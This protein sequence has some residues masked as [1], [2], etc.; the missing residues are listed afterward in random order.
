MTDAVLPENDEPDVAKTVDSATDESDGSY[1]EDSDIEELKKENKQSE[2]ENSA[3]KAPKLEEPKTIDNLAVLAKSLKYPNAK[4]L[5]SDKKT[6]LKPIRGLKDLAAS[7]PTKKTEN[8]EN[9]TDA[10]TSKLEQGKAKSTDALVEPQGKKLPVLNDH[11]KGLNALVADLITSKKKPEQSTKQLPKATEFKTNSSN[12]PDNDTDSSDAETSKPE[13]SKA[14]GAVLVTSNSKKSGVK[15]AKDSVDTKNVKG[16]NALVADLITSTKKTEQS[17]STEQKPNGTED[18]FRKTDE[19]DEYKGDFSSD[20]EK[21]D[22]DDDDK[23]I[24]NDDEPDEKDDKYSKNKKIGELPDKSTGGIDKKESFKSV[25]DFKTLLFGR[26]TGSKK[27]S[28]QKDVLNKAADA[29][30]SNKK[31]EKPKEKSQ[32]SKKNVESGTDEEDEDDTS[33]NDDASGSGLIEKEKEVSNFNRVY[34]VRRK[35]HYYNR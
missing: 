3:K 27:D 2:I 15:N 8:V 1:Q 4:N 35:T 17:S 26:L 11:V 16:L 14:G 33:D 30:E 32:L 12:K 7:K 22:T 6:D 28:K 34:L 13:Q 18:K 23:E 31:K 25:K 20:K 21:T 29:I 5:D 9:D 24:S 19:K 10:E